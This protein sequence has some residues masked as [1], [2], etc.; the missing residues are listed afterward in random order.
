MKNIWLKIGCF[1]SGYNYTL[2]KNSSENSARTVKKY[3]SAIVIIS[4]L[5]GFIGYSFTQRYLHAGNTVSSIVAAIMVI[6]VIQIERQIILSS[7]RNW[8]VLVF[9]TLIG[10][11]MAVIGSVIIDQIIFR[12]DIEK[13]R[14]SN[15]QSEVNR[16]LPEKTV[17]LDN[18]IAQLDAAIVLKEAE[19]A[20]VIDELTRRPFIKSTSSE[21]KHFPMQLN[22]HNG[23]SKD[24]LVKRTDY[25]LTDVANP[26]A[27]LLP[28]ITDQ[29]NQLR[30]QKSEKENS[31]IYARQELEVELQSKTG[32]LDELQVLFSILFSSKIALLVWLMFFLFFMSLEVLVLVNKFGEGTNDYDRILEHQT[33]VHKLMINKLSEKQSA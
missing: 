15:V 28:N 7:G 2:V 23:E 25:T 16:I 29:V 19:R 22:G 18:Q 13:G 27:A 30:K 21:I 33:E 9:R 32:F 11:V 10:V 17:E 6:V 4:I 31:K 12:E 24:T 8:L 5:W 14:I 26:K 1:L 3:F 20:S